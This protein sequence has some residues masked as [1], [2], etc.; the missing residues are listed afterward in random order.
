[1]RRNTPLPDR[2]FA[3][4]SWGLIALFAFLAVAH[5]VLTVLFYA[6]IH[7]QGS[8]FF[9]DF[10]WPS[11]LITVIDASVVLLVW[12]VRRDRTVRPIPVLGATILVATLVIGR[13]AWMVIAP[14]FAAI[15]FFDAVRGVARNR[16]PA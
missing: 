16:L 1:M 10:E 14:I 4:A 13:T 11:W 8:G 6:G 3:V 5:V 9:L 12:L 7:D 15:L 2:L